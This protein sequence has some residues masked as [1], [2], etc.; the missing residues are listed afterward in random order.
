MTSG[1]VPTLHAHVR[2][3]DKPWPEIWA[4]METL[5]RQGHKPVAITRLLNERYEVDLTNASIRWRL[6]RLPPPPLPEP[7]VDP[8]LR[9]RCQRL[10][11]YRVYSGPACPCGEPA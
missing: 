4:M 6:S 11:C 1:T 8:A 5:W 9:R 2:Y 10:G 7:E 3:P